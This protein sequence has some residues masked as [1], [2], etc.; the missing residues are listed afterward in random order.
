MFRSDPHTKLKVAIIGMP[1]RTLVKVEDSAI[2]IEEEMP[3]KMK[4]HMV[5]HHQDFN[6]I[7]E[8]E[9]DYEDK[10]Y[11]RTMECKHKVKFDTYRRGVYC[12]HYC[13]KGHLTKECKF[14]L[15]LCPI[16]KCDDHNSDHCPS[17]SINGTCSRNEIVPIEMV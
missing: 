15:K 9:D 3:M 14:I 11:W 12:Q 4:E 10:Y 1:R 5:K 6:I 16:C 8:S 13:S 2:K 17:M 7:N